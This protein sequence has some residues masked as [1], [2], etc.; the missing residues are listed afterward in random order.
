MEKSSPCTGK[1]SGGALNLGLPQVGVILGNRRVDQSQASIYLI[2][3]LCLPHETAE[4]SKR[5]ETTT[6]RVTVRIL[7]SSIMN[8]GDTKGSFTPDALTCANE[9]SVTSPLYL[10]SKVDAYDGTGA[11]TPLS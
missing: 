3:I 5:I 1:L 6:R 10:K 7:T 8:Q 4:I 2:S 9:S 11:E